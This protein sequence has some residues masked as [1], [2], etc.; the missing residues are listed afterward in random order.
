MA[1]RS[2]APVSLV[3]DIVDEFAGSA[4]YALT[5][6]YRG[7]SL[8]P[9]T[10]ANNS[11]PTS[12]AISLTDFFGASNTTSW[13][14]TVTVAVVTGLFTQSGFLSGSFGSLSDSTVDFL[15]GTPTVSR[16]EFA[17]LASAPVSF[18]IDGSGNSGWTTIKIGNLTLAKSNAN[19]F[20]N[21]LW[22]WTGQSNPFGSNG[23]ETTVVLTQ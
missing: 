18:K 21:G 5:S 16:I 1:V 14:T 22:I 8:V 6:Y 4:P 23:S 15:D 9:N 20:S 13:T 12:G 2:S 7:G 10:T 19:S 3:A 17:S 11:V